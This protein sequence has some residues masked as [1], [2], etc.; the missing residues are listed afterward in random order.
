MIKVKLDKIKRW[1]GLVL[2]LTCNHC[3]WILHSP[4][5]ILARLHQKRTY[6]LQLD[7]CKCHPYGTDC[8]WNHQILDFLYFWDLHR[9]H[10]NEN[11]SPTSSH[12]R[13]WGTQ[14]TWQDP[15]VFLQNGGLLRDDIHWKKYYFFEIL[16]SFIDMF[17]FL[18]Q[19]IFC[20]EFT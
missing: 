14:S 17:F 6:N 20:I 9:H 2:V 3:S 5:A 4:Q 11:I 12:Y 19:Y 10:S 13:V 18:N 1:R 7:P 8:Q 16:L 15:H